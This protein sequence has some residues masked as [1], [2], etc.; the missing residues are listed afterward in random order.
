[1]ESLLNNVAAFFD[2]DALHDDFNWANLE[3]ADILEFLGAQLE[4]RVQLQKRYK[5]PTCCCK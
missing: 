2:E 3:Y 5:T 4:E 1:M